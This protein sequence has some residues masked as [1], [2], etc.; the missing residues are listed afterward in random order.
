MDILSNFSVRN[1]IREINVYVKSLISIFKTMSN[2]YLL[3]IDK[4]N[5]YR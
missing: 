1:V 2:C 3:S 4:Q 5:L